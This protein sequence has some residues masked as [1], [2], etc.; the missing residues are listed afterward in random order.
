MA[1]TAHSLSTITQ[2]VALK[3]SR[4]VKMLALGYP[5]VLLSEDMLRELV[6]DEGYDK[7]KFRPDS[8]DITAWHGLS[9]VMD[10]I[11]ETHSLMEVLGIEMSV[12]D[13]AEVRGG[14]IICDLNMPVDDKFKN[15]FDIVFDGGTMEHCFNVSQAIT[16]ILS[17]AKVGGHVY[18]SNPLTMINHGFY[19]FSPTF[20][21]D[22]YYQ[23]GHRLV[24][25][26]VAVSGNAMN[27]TINDLDG[28]ARP[29]HIPLNA[30]ICVVAEKM[31]EHP[32]IFPTQ[33]K[34]LKSPDLK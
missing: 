11:A 13:M 20:Y 19:N 33:S 8:A 31:N 28:L 26:F 29:Q 16:N 30:T 22:F 6:G 12:I 23:N 10:K 5:D 17:V 1:M 3:Q 2:I 21:Y 18:H 15:S 24:S 32:P 4:P 34:Y 25:K 7:L 9:Q 14:E 27:V